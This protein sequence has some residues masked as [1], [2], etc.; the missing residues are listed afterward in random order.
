MKEGEC[1]DRSAKRMGQEL[2]N[3]SRICALLKSRESVM[4][5]ISRMHTE[6]DC[7][8]RFLNGQSTGSIYPIPVLRERCSE[9]K[10]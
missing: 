6:N 1:I 9:N 4:R 3:L 5:D 7:I 10:L 8:N 2:E